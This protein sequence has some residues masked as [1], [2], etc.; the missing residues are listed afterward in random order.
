MDEFITIVSD[1]TMLFLLIIS[2]LFALFWFGMLIDMFK[3]KKS[4]SERGIWFMFF[5]I[6]PIVTPIIWVFV[7]K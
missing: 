1:K 6:L 3:S 7:R 2:I 5:I 4:R